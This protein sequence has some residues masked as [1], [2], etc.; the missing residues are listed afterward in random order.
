V[1]DRSASAPK[2]RPSIVYTAGEALEDGTL[3]ELLS[4]QPRSTQLSLLCR[5]GKR[6]WTGNR[7]RLG[8]RLY[9]PA[10]IPASVLRQ[11]CLPAKPAN[12]RSARVLFD[13]L[14]Q[15]FRETLRLSTREAQV[16]AY[17]EIATA[18]VDCLRIAPCLTV[19][20]A[21]TGDALQYL[22][23]LGASSRH[24]LT[25]ADLQS[26]G[27]SE[28]PRGLYPTLLFCQ[29]AFSSAAVRTLLAS[30]HRGF[31]VLQCGGIA[32]PYCAK[33]I[34]VDEATPEELAAM[35]CAQVYLAPDRD[36]LVV[37]DAVLFNI[38]TTLQPRLL[39]YRLKNFDAVRSSTFD[40][41]QFVG[42]TREIARAF[43]ACIV[44][45]P[46]LQAGVVAVLRAEDEA[47]R[48][49][50][51]TKPDALVVEALM[52][53][54]H[55][56]NRTSVY[57]G[58]LTNILNGILLG[59]NEGIQFKPR[60]VGEIL[61]AMNLVGDRDAKGYGFLL[62][63]EVRR[64]IHELARTLEVAGLQENIKRCEDCAALLGER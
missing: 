2:R 16:S 59:R 13:A 12:C 56:P 8:R 32:D 45:D 11:M 64:K 5:Q 58:G 57:V 4:P 50:R 53:A 44:D 47:T 49:A 6:S 14:V 24:V 20:A 17:F 9:T 34:V 60:K 54:C 7:I 26:G 33:A 46:E 21:E 22:Q 27:V 28:L 23:V 61:R 36:P 43:G 52:V 29:S 37:S 18:F 31:G 30:Q 51:W 39:D 1:K 25:L 62:M 15:S 10:D 19:F 55:E 41:P 35:P 48:G 3:L 63:N 42:P 38:A 40:V